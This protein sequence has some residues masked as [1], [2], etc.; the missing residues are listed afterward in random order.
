MNIVWTTALF[1]VPEAP[2]WLSVRQNQHWIA[3]ST[4]WRPVQRNGPKDPLSSENATA[5]TLCSCRDI[6]YAPPVVWDQE[7]LESQHSARA[8]K[9][10]D[11]C[12]P[13]CT[14]TLNTSEA[15]E[16]LF[17]EQYLHFNT[18]GSFLLT[19]SSSKNDLTL[20][21]VN[22]SIAPQPAG[23]P[24][25]EHPGWDNYSCR[26]SSYTVGWTTLSVEPESIKWTIH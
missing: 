8:F 23:A 5:P 3:V 14:P 26:R 19:K 1:Q 24:Y 2:G 13:K 15:L 7:A 11:N 9:L 10:A 16:Y 12:E 21:M 6:H 25:C 22:T 4:P 17:I 18:A 20:S